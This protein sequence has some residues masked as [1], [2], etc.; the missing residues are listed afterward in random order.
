METIERAETPKQAETESPNQSQNPNQSQ[1][2]DQ[3]EKESQKPKKPKK[4][5][6]KIQIPPMGDPAQPTPEPQSEEPQK[7][8]AKA[9]PKAKRRRSSRLKNEDLAPLVDTMH[10]AVHQIVDL[11]VQAVSSGR[12]WLMPLT[13]PTLD[14]IRPTG[15]DAARWMLEEGKDLLNPL[16]IHLLVL[17]TSLIPS[18]RIEPKK[19]LPPVEPEHEIKN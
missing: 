11:G 12:G 17:T 8:K 1:S 5:K 9:K 10:R 14:G 18:I 3:S 7:T 15:I 4:Q 6:K 16:E 13:D 2:L 19:E